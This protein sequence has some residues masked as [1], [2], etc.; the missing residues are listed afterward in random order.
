MQQQMS[1]LTILPNYSID[2]EITHNP[3]D[4]ALTDLFQMAA[5]I[6]KKRQFFIYKHCAWQA[7]GCSTA[8]PFTNRSS[9][10]YDVRPAR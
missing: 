7:F 10:S 6:N 2:I 9:F 1:K 4:F 8:N 3:H 5:R